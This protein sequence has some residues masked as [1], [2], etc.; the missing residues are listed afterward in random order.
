MIFF[1][2]LKLLALGYTISLLI[3]QQG[4]LL[5]RH[6]FL[7]KSLCSDVITYN[8][9]LCWI[10]PEYNRS[11]LLLIDGLRLSFDFS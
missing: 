6:V 7:S 9:T 11:I 1:L 10:K 3:F 8:D 5:K 2:R 4:F